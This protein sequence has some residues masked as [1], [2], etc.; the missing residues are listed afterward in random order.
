M[1]TY[2]LVLEDKDAW[3]CTSVLFLQAFLHVD[4]GETQDALVDQNSQLDAT[5]AKDPNVDVEAPTVLFPPKIP[6]LNSDGSWSL[7]ST[8]W[9]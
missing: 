7:P 1:H 2:V 8:C 6:R 9:N 4:Q 3:F 5:P